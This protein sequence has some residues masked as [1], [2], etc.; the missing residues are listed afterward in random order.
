MRWADDEPLTPEVARA[1]TAIDATLDGD[2]VDPS[3]AE[4]AE[5]ALFLR[6]DRP[7][8]AAP[9]A[10]ELDVRVA[11]RF[12]PAPSAPPAGGGGRRRWSWVLA[13][14]AAVGVLAVCVALVFVIGG[15]LG[16]GGSSGP[17]FSSSSSSAAAGAAAS[18][19]AS[20]KS[21]PPFRTLQ[22]SNGSAA[23][24][25]SGALPPAPTPGSTGNRQIVQ[26]A[27]LQLSTA[28]NRVDGVAQEVFDV[29]GQESGIV[30]SSSVTA[31]GNVDGNAVFKLS[32][33]SANLSATLNA[34][35]QLRGATVVSRT[36]ATNDI[37]GQV[38]GAGERLAEARALRTSLLKQLAAATTSEQVDSIKAQLRSADASIASDLSTLNGLKHQVAYSNVI[39]SIQAV[40]PP[41]LVS[42]GGG[43]TMGRAAHDAGRVLVVV[44]G[45]ALI[46][47]AVLVPL[48]L[49]GA[50]VAWVGLAVRR[51]RREHALDLI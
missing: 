23:S 11:R 38:G 29:V 2:P 48:G 18:A 6:E 49:V 4:L 7:E 32:I 42:K 3:Y 21:A 12:R 20:R 13:P 27:Q 34:L 35:S 19:P 9:W 10:T 44:A 22:S 25:A 36:D 47:L 28:P 16:G 33:P 46:A 40:T 8:P 24:S 26:S 17:S 14:G 41:P 30:N 15:G 43:F 50:L 31:T 51:R 45:G 37:T 39:V 1:L 5:L